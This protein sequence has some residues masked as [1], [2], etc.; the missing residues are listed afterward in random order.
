MED[1]RLAEDAELMAAI[2]VRNEDALAALYDR[3][4][5]QC[6]SFAMR[7]LSAE[8]DAED[9]VQ[10][11]FVRVWRSAGQYDGS[12]AGA[13]SWILSITRNLCLDELRRRRRRVPE[14]PMLDGAPEK[15]GEDRTDLE[16]ES[17]IVGQE[18]R[19]A[20]QSLPGEQRSALELVYFHGLTSQEVGRL[21]NVP[22]PTVRS[23]LRL[24]LLKLGG[25]MQERGLIAID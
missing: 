14:M 6:F 10:E 17:R 2:A 21:L 19:A 16:A 22:S 15:A 3:F 23:R 11:T 8:S 13:I 9:A 12:R 7:I 25:I 24:G 5:R 1:F 18:V 4:G 20:L